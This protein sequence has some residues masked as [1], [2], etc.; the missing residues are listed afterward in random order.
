MKAVVERTKGPA[1]LVMD[2]HAFW[3]QPFSKEIDRTPIPPNFREL[4]MNPFDGT[5]DPHAHL[6]AFQT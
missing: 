3:R 5:Q 1:R 6:H 2:T 4:V